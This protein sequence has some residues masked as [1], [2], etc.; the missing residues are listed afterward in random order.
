[1]QLS[2]SKLNEENVKNQTPVDSTPSPLMYKKLLNE[3]NIPQTFP[4]TSQPPPQQQQQ[5]KNA[6]PPVAKKPPPP[7]VKPKPKRPATN[8]L[9]QEQ[10]MNTFSR[11][12]NEIAGSRETIKTKSIGSLK[13]GF[14]QDRKSYSADSETGNKPSDVI[15]T[16]QGLKPSQLFTASKPQSAIINNTEFDIRATNL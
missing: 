11:D 2:N 8:S 13:F 5:Q 14:A 12:V 9:Q 7:L 15:N 1:M 16:E 10:Q 4:K 3:R 6:P